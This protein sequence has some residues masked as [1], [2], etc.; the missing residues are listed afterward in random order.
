MGCS[1][2]KL[3]PEDQFDAE[4]PAPAP[5]SKKPAGRRLFG[6]A[7]VGRRNH[8]RSRSGGT[9]DAAAAVRQ[10]EER[11]KQQGNKRRGEGG[12]RHE[13]A[14]TPGSPS[15]RY[16]CQDDVTAAVAEAKNE[17]RRC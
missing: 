4:Q 6:R 14:R 9:S 5:Q 8:H 11:K 12:G 17:R 16:Y 10:Q 7:V 2:S 3:E 13:Q 1:T 15:F